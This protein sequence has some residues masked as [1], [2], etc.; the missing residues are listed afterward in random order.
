MLTNIF[1]LL[2][3]LKIIFREYSVKK[4]TLLYNVKY[5]I[6]P[7]MKFKNRDELGL[8]ERK[9]ENEYYNDLS[10]KC[11][12]QKNGNDLNFDND[13]CLVLDRKFGANYKIS[14]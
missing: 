14:I 1:F 4:V 3:L 7:D 8:F 2:I 6:K 12:L 5:Y 11:S 10:K 13:Y 9:I